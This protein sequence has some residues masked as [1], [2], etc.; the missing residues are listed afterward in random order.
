MRRLSTIILCIV[1]NISNHAQ[2][3]VHWGEW[4]SWGEQTD[5]TYRNP[6]IPADYS[7]LDCIRVGK[8]YYAI[9]STMQFSPGMTI[10]HSR[11]LVNWEIA[12]N[13]VSD[14]SQ[15]SD[16]MTWR[17]MDRYGRGIWAGTLRYH[18]GRFYLFFG[19][20]DEGFFMTTAKRAEGP[21]EP[22]TPL[23]QEKG[24][25]DC[26]AI[27][28]EQGQAWFVGTC[29][30]DGYKTYI[31]RMAKDGRSIDRSSAR[32]VNEGYGREA[33]K[34]IYHYGYYYL[35]FSEHRDGVGRYVMAKRDRKMTGSFSEERQLLLPCREAYEPNQGGIIEAPSL[36]GR[37]G[38]EAQWYFLTH[39]GTGDWSGRIVS[40][41]PVEWVDGWP[42]IGDISKGS[43]GTMVWQGRMPT[44]Q[45]CSMLNVQRR[46]GR[47]LKARTKWQCSM[48]Q[49]SDDFN[50][51]CLP[52]QWQWNYQPRDDMW[53]LT[54]RPGWLRLHAFTPLSMGE[55]QGVRLLKAGNTLTQRSFRSAQNEVIVKL[56]I[57]HTTDGLHAGLCH[58]AA[59]SASL[60]IVNEGGTNY[61]EWTD[62]DQRTKY[63]AIND[64]YL[65][66]RST[67]GLDGLSRFSYSLDGDHYK[68]LGQY[69][70]SWGFYR[71]DRIGIYC[72]NEREE[73]GY[74]DVDY[75]HYDLA[76][77][78]NPFGHAYSASEWDSFRI[79]APNSTQNR[80]SLRYDVSR[81]PVR[82]WL[83]RKLFSVQRECR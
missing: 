34:L 65:Y 63:Q 68:S 72:F 37:A 28:D 62:N 16:A 42:M 70:L 18:K 19:T 22:L 82:E 36:R 48:I 38:G 27:W 74:V 77:H 66:L 14:L 23:L 58:F 55:G 15:I 76:Q 9:S 11:D 43:P 5:G 29:F 12:G 31:F 30:A 73:K 57:S 61:L 8:D 75:F 1:L 44:S 10:L 80:P 45:K 25:D 71:G 32:L 7:D 26:S 69:Q 47:E 46:R 54:E 3:A 79:F 81:L 78:N 24:W 60:G 67:W 35:V 56:D 39:H 4:Q 2:N 17:Q 20:P 6:I 40:L 59:S 49:R 21:W 51:S 52:P 64:T 50:G 83:K 53:S 13:A 33:N 41:L